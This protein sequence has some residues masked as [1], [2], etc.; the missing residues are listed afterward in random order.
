MH[1]AK[2]LAT[3][4]SE[5]SLLIT[6]SKTFNQETVMNAQT[7]KE[8]PLLWAKDPSAVVKH[9]V[10]LYTNMTKAKE[11]GIDPQNMSKF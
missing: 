4:N 2:T 11:L 6:T 5:S 3:L 10:A 9:F 8:W 1:T 7:V